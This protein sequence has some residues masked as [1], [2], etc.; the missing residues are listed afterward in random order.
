MVNPM[1]AC[2]TV[3]LGLAMQVAA[4]QGVAPLP[5]DEPAAAGAGP[6]VVATPAAFEA[7]LVDAE[8]KARERAASVQVD[9]RSVRMTDP[10]ATTGKPAAGEAHLHYQLDDGPVIATT[11]TKLGF[12]ELAPGNHLIKITL[13]GNDHKPVSAQQTINVT[14]PDS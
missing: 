11:A 4:A 7:T 1:H 12:H 14:I 5:T 9:L 6:A 10:D 13:A 2:S 8:A 3:V